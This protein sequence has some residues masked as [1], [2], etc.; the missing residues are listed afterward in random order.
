MQQF[1]GF[2]FAW[3]VAIV[4]WLPPQWNHREQLSCPWTECLWAHKIQG[5]HLHRFLKKDRSSSSKFVI[6]MLFLLSFVFRIVT[7]TAPRHAEEILLEKL[8]GCPSGP[9]LHVEPRVVRTA[10]RL[11]MTVFAKFFCCVHASHSELG[12]SVAFPEC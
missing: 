7:L 10:A 2:K 11:L 4:M 5:K 6:L 12:A 1:A 3:D 8:F 9:R